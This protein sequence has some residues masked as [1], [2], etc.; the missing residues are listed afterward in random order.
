MNPYRDREP[1]K[2]YDKFPI[3]KKAVIGLWCIV[4]G[5]T[6]VIAVLRGLCEGN[7]WGLYIPLHWLATIPI[8]VILLW[9]VKKRK[10]V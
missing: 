2:P 6:T 5:Y 4:L 1:P 3:F 8:F 10:M 7:W 9:W